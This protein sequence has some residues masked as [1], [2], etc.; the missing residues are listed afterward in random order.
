MKAANTAIGLPGRRTGLACAAALLLGL[1]P[2]AFG[3]TQTQNP[4][5]P[6]VATGALQ[7]PPRN[8]PASTTPSAKAPTPPA[9]APR[10]A[11]QQAGQKSPPLVKPKGPVH[12]A[13]AGTQPKQGAKPSGKLPAA[14]VAGVAAGAAV[15]AAVAT[16]A[17]EPAPPPPPAEP[18]K[19][20]ATSLPLPRFA[21]LRSDEV[22][23]RT[24]P[25]VR[26]P[27]D[28][29]YKRRDLPVQIEREFEVWRLIR[30]QDGVKGWVHQATLTGRRSFMVTGTERVMHRQASPDASPVARLQPGVLGHIR[31]CEATAQWCQV[32]VGEYKGWLKR[33]EFWGILPNEAIN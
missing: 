19:G 23:L 24:G 30:D 31:S 12:A 33:D 15:G 16:P 2:A 17:T 26:Y 1:S 18:P 21:A 25:G 10:P 27:I 5:Q 6:P 28:W 7:A 32:Q 13:P 8:K 3:Q 29:V 20:T 14:A 22:N 9:A 11:V 4:A